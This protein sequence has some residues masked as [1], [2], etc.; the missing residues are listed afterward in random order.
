MN[1]FKL[2]LR[3]FIYIVT[4]PLLIIGGLELFAN[5]PEVQLAFW[6]PGIMLIA[7]SVIRDDVF[8]RLRLVK[9]R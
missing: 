9:G 2:V 7:Y 5:H 6:V 4:F 3:Y 1:N 8:A